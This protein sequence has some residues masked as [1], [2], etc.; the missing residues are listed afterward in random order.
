MK[1]DVETKRPTKLTLLQ[2]LYQ[3]ESA[4]Y[5]EKLVGGYLKNLTQVKQF[6]SRAMT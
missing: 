4:G 2:M 5:Y 1:N 6:K 3:E